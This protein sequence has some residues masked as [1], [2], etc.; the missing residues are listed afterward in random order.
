MKMAPSLAGPTAITILNVDE[1]PPAFSE[2]LTLSSGNM[3]I[4]WGS[5][6]NHK[7]TVHYSTN[8]QSGFSVMQSNISGT[9]PINIHTVLSTTATQKFWKV[10]TDP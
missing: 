2:P 8:L 6:T 5:I 4:R 1:L 9:P 3:V 10:T 7:Y